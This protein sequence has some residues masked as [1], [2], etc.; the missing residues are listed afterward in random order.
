V[1]RAFEDGAAAR[2]LE[3][4]ELTDEEIALLQ[5]LAPGESL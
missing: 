5:A 3:E 1:K 2:L 4:V